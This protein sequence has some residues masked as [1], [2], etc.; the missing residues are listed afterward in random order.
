MGL[1]IFLVI[2]FIPEPSSLDCSRPGLPAK[3]KP[4]M[5]REIFLTPVWPVGSL[6]VEED[7]FEEDEEGVPGTCFLFEEPGV[8]GDFLNFFFKGVAATP[9]GADV[10]GAPESP[11]DGVEKKRSASAILQSL[12]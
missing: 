1:Q 2:V 3:L 4:D 12:L 6:A 8:W 9:P 7:V 10:D 11:A 5:G